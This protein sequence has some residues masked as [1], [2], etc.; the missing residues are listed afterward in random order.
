[1]FGL[2]LKTKQQL[3]SIKQNE[4]GKAERQKVTDK[5]LV[6]N[7]KEKTHEKMS[8]VRWRV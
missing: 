4:D 7:V 5:T 3:T 8:M 1:M 2:K 6:A